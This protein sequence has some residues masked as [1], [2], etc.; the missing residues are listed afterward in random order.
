MLRPPGEGAEPEEAEPPQ[1]DK[2]TDAKKAV[3]AQKIIDLMICT[4]FVISK[5]YNVFL[6]RMPG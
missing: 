5:K 4:V 1:P 2:R 3:V 6:A